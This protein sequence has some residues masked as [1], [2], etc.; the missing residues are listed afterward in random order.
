MTHANK[1]RVAQFWTD[2]YTRDW[3]LVGTY[4]AADSEY[5]D[6]PTPADDVARG[7]EQIVTRLRIGLEPL[8]RI[9][10]DV[11]MVV[12]EGDTVVTEHVEHWEWPT[13]E[14]AALPFVS[15]QEL[16][17]GRIVRWWDYWDLATLMGAAPEW[18]VTQIMQSAVEAGLRES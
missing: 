16:R 7:P 3:N 2:L 5:T 10:H 12:A 18:W 11:R 13:G 14:H 15:V 17:D 6:V 4:F 9:S 8:A 1:E